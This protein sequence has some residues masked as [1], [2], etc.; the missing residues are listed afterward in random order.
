[1]LFKNGQ[2]FTGEGFAPGS[3]RVEQGRFTEL[4]GSNPAG[5]G[6]DLNGAAVIPGLVDI[7]TH[8]NSGADFSDGD[9]F[10]I[11]HDSALNCNWRIC[12][13]SL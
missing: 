3:F 9:V 1:M 13:K 5:D 10:F 8:G 11:M 12:P 2:I 7:H 4:L 6:L